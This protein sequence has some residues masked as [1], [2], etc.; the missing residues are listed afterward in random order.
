MQA[1][2]VDGDLPDPRVE[3]IVNTWNWNI[4]PWWLLIPQVESGP[5]PVPSNAEGATPR[6]SK[7][8]AM[9]RCRSARQC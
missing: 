7:W 6:S 1:M 5:S 9:D 4:T 2:I 8:A 3:V